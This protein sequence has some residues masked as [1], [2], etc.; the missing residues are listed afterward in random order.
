MRLRAV[1]VLCRLL[2]FVIVMAGP[3][4]AQTTVDDDLF[5]RWDEMAQRVQ[6]VLE[7]DRANDTSLERLRKE[8][9]DYRDQFLTAQNANSDRLTRVQRQLDAL[10]PAPA[11][12]ESED[13]EVATRR[14]QLNDEL[15]ALR[16]P[17]LRATEAFVEADGFIA[18]IDRLVRERQA[19]QVLKR[20]PSPINPLNWAPPLEE[21]N[22]ALQAVPSEVI[23]T[24]Q[25]D[26]ARS[27]VM[28]NLPTVLFLL[29]GGG[30]LLFRSRIWIDRLMGSIDQLGGRALSRVLKFLVVLAQFLLPWLG[31]LLLLAALQLTGLFGE[32]GQ[33]LVLSLATFG[34]VMI[35]GTWLIRQLYP[36]AAPEKTPL[37]LPARLVKK[38]RVPAQVMVLTIAIAEGLDLFGQRQNFD[39]R[40]TAYLSVFLSV[41]TALAL[42]RTAHLFRR[43]PSDMDKDMPERGFVDSVLQ[44]LSGGAMMIAVAGPVAGALGYV[45]LSKQLVFSAAI[46]FFLFGFMALA[47][48]EIGEFYALFRRRDAAGGDQQEG[49]FPTLAGAVLIVASL[50]ILALIWGA[51]I[52]DLTEVWTKFREGFVVG[53]VKISPSEF[54]TF[55]IV[56]AL[57]YGITRLLQGALST[58]VLPKTRLDQGART[59]LVSGI[60]YVGVFAAA[61]MAVTT[62]GIDLS[63]FAI[64]ASALAVGIG[65]GL[66]TIVSNFVSGIILLIERP[67]SE[68]DWVQVGSVHGTVDRISVRSTVIQAFDRSKVIVP[69]AD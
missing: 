39:A 61:V 31:L 56:F 29:I 13:P 38:A 6:R 11:E 55:A 35:A 15:A 69:N 37:R 30:F 5:N 64:F 50:P 63:A 36:R 26:D 18:E 20:Y 14:K 8:V 40:S 27:Q 19:R 68:G 52:T 44:V 10:G 22:T 9:A 1:A 16:R 12:G 59:A 43:R 17:V 41:V 65:F 24:L 7:Y 46:S 62:A 4:W 42:Y 53:D 66:Q 32:T 28:Q 58:T 48:R 49:L 3:A 47:Q 45:M 54:L 51:R 25:D 23:S 67:V 21:V 34:F 33:S 2:A 60:G 57:G